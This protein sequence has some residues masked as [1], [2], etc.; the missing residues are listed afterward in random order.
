VPRAV[1]GQDRHAAQT[2]RFLSSAQFAEARAVKFQQAAGHRADEQMPVAFEQGRDRL[3]RAVRPV[4]RGQLRA[5]VFQQ[6]RRARADVKP[7]VI[8]GQRCRDG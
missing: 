6:T 4:Q 3:R 1:A 5:V 7:L 8:N 2:R